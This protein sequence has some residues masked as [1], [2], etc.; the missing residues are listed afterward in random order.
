MAIHS[1]IDE[2]E[3]KWAKWKQRNSVCL[4]TTST[5]ESTETYNTKTGVYHGI[6]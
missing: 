1:A 6:H 4:G 3:E 2:T 5:W